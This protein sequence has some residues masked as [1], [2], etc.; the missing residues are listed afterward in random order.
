MDGLQHLKINIAPPQIRQVEGESIE[1][2]T[3]EV[4]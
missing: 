2:D 4:W 1:N 3:P